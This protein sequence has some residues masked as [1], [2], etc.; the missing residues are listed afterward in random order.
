MPSRANHG[1]ARL[2][3]PSLPLLGPKLLTQ[4]EISEALGPDSRC[5]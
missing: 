3:N 2:K 5:D 4:V 1:R